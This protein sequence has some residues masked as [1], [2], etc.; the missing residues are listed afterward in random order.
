MNV[1]IALSDQPATDAEQAAHPRLAFDSGF[2]HEVAAR[3][4]QGRFAG[5]RAYLAGP[6]VM[7]EAATRLLRERGVAE[8]DIHA[9]AF[10]TEADRQTNTA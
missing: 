5:L 3:R 9:D 8:R 4:M 2:V 10:Y 7:V 1:T 6:P